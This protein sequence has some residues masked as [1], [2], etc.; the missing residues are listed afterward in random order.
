MGIFC[1]GEIGVDN[2]IRVSHLPS[3][4]VAA[5]PSSE[6]YHI[7]GAAAN[8]AVWLAHW[9]AP[10]TLAGNHIGMDPYGVALKGWLEDYE[11]LNLT[12]LEQHETA[13]TPFCRVMVTPDGER[14]FLIFGYQV[15][16]KTPL[17]LEMLST[18]KFLALDLYGGDERLK[19][20]QIAH[21][22]G[23]ATVTGDIIWREHEVLPLTSI[24]TNSAAYIR[25]EFP[26]MDVR[27]QARAL[28]RVS[29]GVV[30]T[31]N[32]AQAIHVI[33]EDA[34]EF[35][36]TPPHVVAKDATG[37]GDAFRAGLMYGLLHEYSLERSVCLGAAAGAFGVQEEGAASNPASLDEVITLADSLT[38]EP[39][40]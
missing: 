19:A 2:L 29:N 38:V 18:S 37:A 22:A 11:A 5:F 35:T 30:V 15:S 1:Y 13:R 32:G 40:H 23:V 26:G 27:D 16:Q 3:P 24:A 6:T 7:G 25:Q 8:T 9:H 31:T 36:V 39:A 10:V 34:S 14:S 20:A 4:E 12:H 21:E 17:T 33:A 28:Q